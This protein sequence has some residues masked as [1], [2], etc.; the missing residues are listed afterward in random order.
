MAG[1]F[2]PCAHCHLFGDQRTCSKPKI[3]IQLQ[4]AK[5][6]FG[7]RPLWLL[8]QIKLTF[9]Y[10]CLPS[11]RAIRLYSRHSAY[12]A[13]TSGAAST[14]AVPVAFSASTLVKIFA[15]SLYRLPFFQS[16]ARISVVQQSLRTDGAPFLRGQQSEKILILQ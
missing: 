10:C 16:G 15:N 13:V 4:R 5:L 3:R 12:L 8:T 1:G 2:S 9:R 7:P 14:Q 6:S 11:A